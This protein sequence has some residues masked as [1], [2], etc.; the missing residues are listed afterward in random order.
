MVKNV[1]K[2]IRLESPR[3]YLD[4]SLAGHG[5]NTRKKKQK[6][7]LPSTYNRLVLKHRSLANVPRKTSQLAKFTQLNSYGTEEVYFGA[8]QK[9]C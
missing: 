6:G 9:N 3:V 1:F 4:T 5:Y 2:H 7:V 8:R